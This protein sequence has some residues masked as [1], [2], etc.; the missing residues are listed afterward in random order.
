[1]IRLALI[2]SIATLPALLL[3]QDDAKNDPPQPPASEAAEQPADNAADPL[4]TQGEYVGTVRG[5][6]VAVQVAAYG[7]GQYVGRYFEGG[8]P[9]DG[10]NHSITQPL[11]GEQEKDAVRLYGGLQPT[12]Y[13]IADGMIQASDDQGNYVGSLRRV[14]RKSPTLGAKPPANA[15]VLFDGEDTSNLKDAKVTEDGLL[16]MGFATAMPVTDFRL[17]LE[18][19]T[20][21]MP[22]AR[23]QQRGNSGVYIQQRYEVQI[24]DAFTNEPAKNEIGALYRQQ[25]PDMN[26]AYPPMQWQTYDIEFTAAR[27]GEDGKTKTANAKVTV[28]L[29]GVA[30]HYNREIKNKTG[31]GKPEGPNPLPILFQNH[32]DPVRFR[33]M[34]IVLKDE[35]SE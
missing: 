9:G 19:R 3:A 7:K 8:L 22:E 17:H 33:N 32:R 15:T 6:Q 20:P 31:A 2:L 30:V 14:E 13:R 34:W 10:W 1:M 28:F 4:A 18:F 11:S 12:V 16:E 25:E 5:R 23:G 35:A 21:F 26:M 29:N 27:F 24:L